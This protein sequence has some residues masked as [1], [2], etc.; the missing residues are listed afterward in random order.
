LIGFIRLIK[1]WNYINLTKEINKMKKTYTYHNRNYHNEF[2]FRSR[3]PDNETPEE[4]K[5]INGEK[6]IEFCK[7]INRAIKG[8]DKIVRICNETKEEVQIY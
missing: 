5:E 7:S 2:C 3:Y 1:T 8:S 4:L 6:F